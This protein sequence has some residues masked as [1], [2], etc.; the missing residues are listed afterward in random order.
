MLRRQCPVH[1]MPGPYK[2][3]A[4]RFEAVSVATHKA[5][6]GVYR[7]V[8]LP[9]G[10]FVTERLLDLGARKLGL[11]PAA[12]RLCNMIRKEEHPYTT[13]LGTEIESGAIANLQMAL[14][15]RSAVSSAAT[16]A[17]RTAVLCWCRHRMLRRR[18]GAE[19]E[20]TTGCG[21][22]CRRL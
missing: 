21:I 8:G 20:I 22:G 12:V 7:G 4:F 3:P 6:I 1:I 17:A 2:V 19:F 16:T 11:D 13:I 10:V 9:I 15:T 5:T 18:H 14:D